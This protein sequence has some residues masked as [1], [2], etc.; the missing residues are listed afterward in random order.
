MTHV[1][2]LPVSLTGR[3]SILMNSHLYL[4]YLVKTVQTQQ[5]KHALFPQQPPPPT[6]FFMIKGKQ[7]L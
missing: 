7:G 3:P 5:I 4:T 1:F 2:A 6:L